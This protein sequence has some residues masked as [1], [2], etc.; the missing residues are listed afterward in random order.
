MH[1]KHTGLRLRQI[2]RL[3]EPDAEPGPSL[4]HC[5]LRARAQVN[6]REWVSIPPFFLLSRRSLMKQSEQGT[7]NW[8]RWFQIWLQKRPWRSFGFCIVHEN[9]RNFGG[10]EKQ[11]YSC[12]MSDR[13]RCCWVFLGIGNHFTGIIR[14]IGLNYTIPNS[15]SIAL[16]FEINYL[17]TLARKSL[18]LQ[19]CKYPLWPESGLINVGRLPSLLTS[20]ATF[21][22]F[23]ST[24]R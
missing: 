11:P 21:E 16:L 5:C 13:C 7:C 12:M 14:K 23:R 24:E 18:E 15:L 19:P 2:I 10:F 20:R 8:G 1:I 17:D 6:G 22:S 4:L 9:S 3:S